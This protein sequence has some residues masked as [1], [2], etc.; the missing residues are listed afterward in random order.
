M[1]KLMVQVRVRAIAVA[2]TIG[3]A[4][5]VYGQ[6]I[7][8]PDATLRA[9]LLSVIPGCIDGGGNLDLS[10]PSVVALSE[11]DLQVD[12]SP[13]DL[14]GLHAMADLQR[15]SLTFSCEWGPD[16]WLPCHDVVWSIPS[17]PPS[18]TGLVLNKGTTAVIPDL[19]SSLTELSV[20]APLGAT[21]FPAL[22]QGLL[23]FS[24]TASAS[25]PASPALPDGLLDLSLVYVAGTPSPDLPASLRRLQLNGMDA[26]TTP[27][28]PAGLTS[29]QI[30]R[31]NVTTLPEWPTGLERLHVLA[32]PALQTIP[33]FTGALDTL[34]LFMLPQVEQLPAFPMTV[35]SLVLGEMPN[36][37][38]L[39]ELPEQLEGLQTAFLNIGS[40]PPLPNALRSWDMAYLPELV[41]LPLLPPGMELLLVDV[42]G[43]GF[44]GTAFEC[45]PNFPE[46]MQYG[47]E[48]DMDIPFSPA[49]LCTVLNSTCEFVNPVATGTVYA[50]QNANGIQDGG[51]TGYPFA[52]IA[53]QPGNYLFGVEPDGGFE[54]P[55]PLDQYSLTASSSNPY[56]LSISPVSHSAP[57]TA[58]TDVDSS[59]D[60]GVVLQPNVQ[61]LRID[62]S[63]PWGRPGYE[64]D[65]WLAYENIGTIAMD[66]TITLQLDADLA[67][68]E[69]SPAP[70]M[71]MGQTITWNFMDLQVGESR[72][73]HYTVYTDAAVPLGT[74]VQHTATI[75]PV[76][77]DEDATDNVDVTTGEVVGSFDPNDKRVEPTSL[78]PA[79]VAAGS[80]L[81]YTIRFQNTGTYQADCVIITDT[82]SADLQWSTMRLM[83]SS[84]PCTWTILGNGVLRFTFDPIVLPDSTSDEPN[85]HGFVKFAMKP[86]SALM[87]GE[88][89]GNVANIY[90]DYNEPVITNEAVFTVDES[91]SIRELDKNDLRVWPNPVDDELW[92]EGTGLDR[93]EILD[94]TG[95]VVR[96]QVVRGSRVAVDVSGSL[97]GAYVL[98]AH[99]ASGWRTA[100]FLKR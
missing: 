91:T 83:S 2:M 89:V 65:G 93:I 61:D 64:S 77:S 56:V 31:F 4:A 78:T 7:F 57:F 25:M 17:W 68:V 47:R 60:F 99:G 8:V 15:L 50:D 53:T 51:E 1:S 95:R 58:P 81:E 40:V 35:R 14:T 20:S 38:S 23:K 92:V 86:S 96:T 71:V 28:W 27:V 85:S 80:E 48:F 100:P 82:L 12:W 49:L 19:P 42:D 44:I 87:N 90:F 76:V 69:G 16:N 13:A 67:W 29:L 34:Y 75:G 66:G 70:S 5:M 21:V 32:F 73:I 46:G 18:L 97:H 3:S 45:L 62:Q 41:C 30:S 98:R 63:W 43:G 94:I 11:L 59:N 55:L 39:P 72:M 88:S 74:D 10:H 24:Y 84:H 6:L 79:Q 9:K 52:T 33:A 22:P 37:A 26:A 54:L 36:V